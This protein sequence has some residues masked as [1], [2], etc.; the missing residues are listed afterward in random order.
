MTPEELAKDIALDWG[1]TSET[2]RDIEERIRAAIWRERW[3]CAEAVKQAANDI[4][5]DNAN[6][7]KGYKAGIVVAIAAIRARGVASST[8]EIPPKTPDNPSGQK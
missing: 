3:E 8:Q 7:Y 1:M 4:R 5:T 6:R 2:Q